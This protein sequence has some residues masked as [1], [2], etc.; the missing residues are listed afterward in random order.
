MRRLVG[1]SVALVLA[2]FAGLG[3]EERPDEAMFWKIRQEATARSQILQTVHVLTDVYG[4]RLTGS[5]NLKAAGEWAVK[6]LTSWGLTNGHLE[7]W[8]FGKDGWANERVT[9]HLITPV[10]DALVVEVLAWTPSTTGVARGQ[11]MQITLPTRPSAT[12]LTDYLERIKSTVKGKMVLVG[13]HQSVPVTFNPA[14]LRREDADV[15]GLLN[16]PPAQTPTFVAPPRADQVA[17]R[18]M[19]NAQIQERVNQFLRDNGALVRINDAGRDHGQI[20]A[21]DNA[22]RD[23]AKAPPTVVM[24]N[25][26]YGRISRLLADKRQVELEFEIVNRS[27]PE[28]RTSYNVIAEIPGTDKAD[29]VVMLGG[30][31][32]S[33]H[34]ATGATDNAIGCSVMMEAVRILTAVGAKPRRT[35]RVALWSG[36]EQGLLGSAAYVRQHFGTFEDQKAEYSKLSAYFNMDSGTGRI[37]ALTAF[38]PSATG[39]VLR[40]ATASFKDL[41][42]LGATSTRS[43]S[44]G[45]T[46]STNFNA[47]GLPGINTLL[48]PIQ[49]QTYTWHTNLDTYERIVEDDVKKAAIVI[50]GAVYHLA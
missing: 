33:W 14:A 11:A 48:D 47:A 36:E 22:T 31:L 20:R 43:R 45:G 7:P 15:V 24:R 30:H 27:Y 35:I 2:T 16:T 6:Q 3:A 37:R 25:E 42:M 5:P 9:A 8:D 26:D 32:D 44:T 41:G 21:F 12:D 18:V 17:Q 10:K 13:P 39:D 29:E 40:E 49:Y 1:V 46:D 50:A 19:T 28:G 4:P 23:I 34:A 38:G